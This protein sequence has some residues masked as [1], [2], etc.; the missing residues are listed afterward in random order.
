M[1]LVGL[2][3]PVSLLRH[4]KWWEDVPPIGSSA[5]GAAQQ[6]SFGKRI[7]HGA[8]A[9]GVPQDFGQ[10]RVQEF[11]RV[12]LCWNRCCCLPAAASRDGILLLDRGG[13]ERREDGGGGERGD[14]KGG[15][16]TR[17]HDA[18]VDMCEIG[19]GVATFLVSSWRHPPADCLR[20]L[21][22]A[23]TRHRPF[24]HRPFSSED[25]STVTSG[26]LPVASH[27]C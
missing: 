19:R 23:R 2:P 17:V 5:S 20:L 22:T 15:D 25:T 18:H 6:R 10:A 24:S 4:P 7:R 27:T 13:R 26:V 16:C 9:G 1:R 12:S 11:L 14:G 8:Q 21:I 3:I